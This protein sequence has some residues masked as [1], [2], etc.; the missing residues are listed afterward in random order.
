MKV[1][2]IEDEAPLARQ[3]ADTIRRINHE[4]TITGMIESVEEA[5]GWL[6]QNDMPDLIFS[7]I[8]LADGLSFEIYEKVKVSCPIIFCT[9]FDEYLLQAFET[10]AISYLLKPVQPDKI[11]QALDKLAMLRQQSEK[12]MVVVALQRLMRQMKPAYKTS[13]LIN[14]REKIIPVLIKDVAYFCLENTVIRAHMLQHQ[15]YY[16]TTS[17]D[18]L[19]KIIDPQIFYRANRQYLINRNAVAGVERFFSRKLAVKLSVETPETIIVS[20]IK[21]AEFL[22][23]LEGQ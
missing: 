5:I 11:K 14:H 22:A 2:I 23:W 15:Q 7:D 1:L 4:V 18:E 12:D 17:L 9:A 10:N 8:H 16:L 21:T 19:E 13:L 3:L 6:N 20:K